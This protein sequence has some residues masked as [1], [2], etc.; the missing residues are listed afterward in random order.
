MSTRGEEE[1]STNSVIVRERLRRD[2]DV[3]DVRRVLVYRVI[4]GKVAEC[5]VLDEDERLIDNFWRR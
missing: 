2:E 4:D 1:T 5:W 3:A